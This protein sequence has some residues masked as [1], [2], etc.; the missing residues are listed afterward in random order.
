MNVKN[1]H[2]VIAAIRS[3]LE[4]ENYLETHSLIIRHSN[5]LINPRFALCEGG[6]LRDSMETE[7]RKKVSESTPKVYEIGPCFRHETDYDAV[8][9]AEFY[10][11]ELYSLN[12]SLDVMVELT[13]AI[14][15]KALPFVTSTKMV[16][17]KDMICSEF[18]GNFEYACTHDLVCAIRSKYSGIAGTHDAYHTIINRYIEKVV[19]PLLVEKDTLYFL[20]EYP[21]CTIT[22]AKQIQNTGF[23]ERFECF[24]NG[25]EIANSFVDCM[26]GSSVRERV[27]ASGVL[28]SE[29]NEL[30]MLLHNGSLKET[31]GLGI[32]VDRLCF[33]SE[34]KLS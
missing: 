16:S 13:K 20:T 3:C 7:L 8:H 6:F 2:Q 24:I 28:D 17:I 31:V 27:I 15:Q 30:V 34:R 33:L 32:G 29:L 26:D 25:I 22:V 9:L 23:I 14:V 11:M 21:I 10:M 4:K 18:G 19:E 5:S 12:E 1:R